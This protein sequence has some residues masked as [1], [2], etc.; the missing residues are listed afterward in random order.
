MTSGDSK[1]RPGWAMATP[2]VWLAPCFAPTFVRN[3][4]FMFF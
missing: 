2:D 1:G 4:T 3:F